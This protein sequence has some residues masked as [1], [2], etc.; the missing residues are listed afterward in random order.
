MRLAVWTRRACQIGA[1]ARRL[2]AR[3]SNALSGTLQG[4]L[5]PEFEWHRDRPWRLSALIQPT[6][7]AHVAHIQLE[8]RGV[9][10]CRQRE[11]SPRNEGQQIFY[12][13]LL[14][15]NDPIL[16]DD[17]TCLDTPHKLAK[18]FF[19]ADCNGGSYSLDDRIDS[20]SL[21]GNLLACFNDSGAMC[22]KF[23]GT[24]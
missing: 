4:C 15:L 2:A 1:C 12:Q 13:R 20:L 3:S 8:L 21:F 10:V 16:R 11:A 18:T 22:G 17:T 5:Q 19:L 23:R 24:C 14:L 9:D 6:L 7:P